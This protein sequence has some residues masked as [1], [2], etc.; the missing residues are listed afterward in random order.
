MNALRLL[1]LVLLVLLV[2]A[3]GATAVRMLGGDSTVV[4]EPV[5]DDL[6]ISGGN[7]VIDA[8][9]GSLIAVGGDIRVNGPVTGDVIAAGGQVRV[10]GSVGGK[11]VLAG[12][13]VDVDANVSRNAVIAGGEVAFGP[14]ARIG[15]DAQVAAGS[16]THRG[17][18]NGSLAVSAET[19]T[20]QGTAG[21]IEVEPT[22][23][24]PNDGPREEGDLGAIGAFFALIAAILSLLVTLGYLVLGI[25]LIAISPGA[26]REVE[27]RVV[28]RPVPAF[29][30]GL[31]ALIAAVI[32]GVLL[33]VTVIGI[34]IAVFAWL[35]VIA[36]VMVAGL[37]VSLALGR[38]IAGRTGIGENP[39]LLFVIG[40]V[41]LNILYLI[42]FLGGLVKFVAVC[43]GFGAIVMYCMDA[44]SAAQKPF[45]E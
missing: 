14:G 27:S 2:L 11:V 34:P 9:I 41:I 35:F 6:F 45:G 13:R 18:V 19:F 43:L 3:P 20:N 24:T 15:R 33:F 39:Y 21:S 29:A 37:V 4:T 7:V 22:P 5:D 17:A 12:G 44:R 16:F 30:I 40:F 42:P 28:S 36:G 23:G 25:V 26:A 8:P 1:T 10:N 31:A 38:L 32:L